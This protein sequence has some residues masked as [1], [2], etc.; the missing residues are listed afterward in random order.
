MQTLVRQSN[1]IALLN[2]AHASA[3]LKFG[4]LCFVIAVSAKAINSA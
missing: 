1:D 3:R 2:E 4:R